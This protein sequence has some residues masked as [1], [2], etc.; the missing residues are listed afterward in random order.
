MKIVAITASVLEHEK[1]GHMAAGFH[2]FLGKPFRF[3]E[4]CDSLNQLLKVDFEYAKEK[5]ET[6]PAPMHLDPESVTLPETVLTELKDAADRYSVT[7]LEQGLAGLEKMDDAGQ[8]VAA[9]LRHF[10]QA[11]DLESVGAFLDQ[12]K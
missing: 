4:V 2:G 7:R 1:A 3:E 6:Q 10:I 12:V 8:R 11:G 5:V 9:H